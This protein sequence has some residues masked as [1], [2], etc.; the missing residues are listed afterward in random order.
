MSSVEAAVGGGTGAGAP[1]QM[2]LSGA[3][4]VHDFEGQR[5]IQGS[6]K[7]KKRKEMNLK[8]QRSRFPMQASSEAD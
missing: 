5:G 2:D 3:E 1:P 8:C 4:R 7:A 6:A